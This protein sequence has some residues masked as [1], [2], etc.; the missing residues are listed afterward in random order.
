MPNSKIVKVGN[1]SVGNPVIVFLE[2]KKYTGKFVDLAKFYVQMMPANFVV[3]DIYFGNQYKL[4]LMTSSGFW[5]EELAELKLDVGRVSVNGLE[6]VIEKIKSDDIG[7]LE[8]PQ[9]NLS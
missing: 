2:E 4:S 7:I 3:A 9:E 6:A 8:E 1:G 5:Q